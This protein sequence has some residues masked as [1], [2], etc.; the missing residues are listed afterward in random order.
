MIYKQFNNMK[1][2]CFQSLQSKS[3]TS[4]SKKVARSWSTQNTGK[5]GSGRLKRVQ[6][7]WALCWCCLYA[8]TASGWN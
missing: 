4:L 2:T 5:F 6:G 3:Y 1:L 7:E 8:V